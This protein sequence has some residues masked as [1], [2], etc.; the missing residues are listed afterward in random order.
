MTPAPLHL[1]GERLMLDPMG[2]VSWPARRTLVVSD[3]HLEKGSHFAARGH[4]VPPYD[5]RETLSRLALAVRRYRPARLV[6]L[7]DSFHD[8]R[9]CERMAPADCAAL[10]RLLAEVE[11]VVWVLGNHDPVAPVGLPGMASASL[12]DGPITFRHEAD[13]RAV[14]ELSGHFHPK[15]AL[16]TRAGTISR[17]CFATDARRVILPAFGAYTGGLDVRDPAL[18]GLFPR[19]GRAFMLGEGRLFSIPMPPMRRPA[20]RSPERV[21]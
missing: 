10:G 5:T 14:G 11:E 19:G 12:A 4:F 13:F 3:L 6:L 16:A 7:G 17:P 20:Q 9:G 18:G 2:V 1:S 15:A 21:G 8:P